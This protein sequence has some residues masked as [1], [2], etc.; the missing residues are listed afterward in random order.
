MEHDV[1]VSALVRAAPARVQAV[2]VDDL[3]RVL[4]GHGSDKPRGARP[5]AGKLGVDVGGGASLQQE[6]VLEPGAP[7]LIDDV[8]LVPLRIHARGHARLFPTFEGELG[9][10]PER[11]GTR[12]RLVGRS[13]VPLGWIGN[14]GE[15]VFSGE[16]LAR[17]SLARF[18]EE[19]AQR[20]DDAVDRQLTSGQPAATNARGRRDGHR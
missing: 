7:R 3:E 9:A 4:S 12:I 18:V 14:V 17:E 16:R 10:S 13:T 11:K 8:L 5:L 20:V 2:F 6:V 19:I 1:E 15:G